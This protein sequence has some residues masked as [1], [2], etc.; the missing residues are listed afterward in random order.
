MSDTDTEAAPQLE[1]MSRDELIKLIKDQQQLLVFARKE[2][3]SLS[4]KVDQ[5]DKKL[6]QQKKDIAQYK[7]KAELYDTLMA[8]EA[9]AARIYSSSFREVGFDRLD[10]HLSKL[11]SMPERLIAMSKALT[12]LL[13]KYNNYL[14]F[15]SSRHG[16]VPTFD[17]LKEQIIV[18]L[19]QGDGTEE[20]KPLEMPEP[21][22][23]ADA[24]KAADQQACA[25]EK[26]RRAD[27]NEMIARISAEFSVRLQRRTEDNGSE[28]LKN[29]S[30][31]GHIPPETSALQRRPS[32][33]RHKRR[34]GHLERRPTDKKT[35]QAA[36]EEK[37]NSLCCPECGRVDWEYAAEACLKEVLDS[38]V[39]A[40]LLTNP[41]R[42]VYVAAYMSRQVCCRYCGFTDLLEAGTLPLL[43]DRSIA[44]APVMFAIVLLGYGLPVNTT[45][46]LFLKEANLGHSTLNDSIIDAAW[47]LQ[48]IKNWGADAVSAGTVIHVD[49]TKY[50]I[51]D[52]AGSHQ[53]YICMYASPYDAEVQAVI[54]EPPQRRSYAAALAD[55]LYSDSQ[56]KD[57][58]VL[59][60]DALASYLSAGKENGFDNQCCLV[61]L[62]RM[63]RDSLEV[64]APEYMQSIDLDQDVMPYLTDA[65]IAAHGISGKAAIIVMLQIYTMLGSIFDF[66]A[67]AEREHRTS[68]RDLI[69]CR[70]EVRTAHCLPLMDKID[71][72]FKALS[73][74]RVVYGE[75]GGLSKAAGSDRFTR[76]VFYYQHNRDC[77]RTFLR[78]CEASCHNN[79]LERYAKC[80][81]TLRN[82]AIYSRTAEAG[83][84]VAQILTAIHTASA[85]GITNVFD[86][87]CDAALYSRR[88]C[89]IHRQ[90]YLHQH[91]DE[92]LKNHKLRQSWL[93][94]EF[95]RK[96][97]L[98]PELQP[99]N[100]AK[101]SAP[102]KQLLKKIG[103]A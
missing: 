47:L 31:S 35:L 67:A 24:V 57:Q 70:R 89:I 36:I 73:A 61:H 28:F 16:N 85:N 13:L 17:M 4:S 45:S 94:K 15:L 51:I 71:S 91:K 6:S 48:V 87:I 41:E 59:C 23:S 62:Y 9:E 96:L 54:F 49:E 32:T 34:D 39:P 63:V 86:Y 72:M 19:K 95:L 7:R 60:S 12:D 88:M 76:A 2:N 75:R 100:Y 53:R 18:M 5:Q 98:P 103:A 10:E 90:Q 97:K 65:E 55:R 40:G 30:A 101:D 74:G 79:S 69:E 25:K 84:G 29:M 11:S 83:E 38:M 80:V 50:T 52:D 64:I 21:E 93:D 3:K 77:F 1:T 37:K 44:L 8:A 27:A 43:P 56:H 99:H 66:E 68:G 33:G 26:K 22:R 42:G 102:A 46:N 20:P 14:P 82:R 58:L 92:L 81:A 78:R